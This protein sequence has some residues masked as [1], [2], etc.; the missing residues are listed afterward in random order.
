MADREYPYRDSMKWIDRHGFEHFTTVQ[1]DNAADLVEGV[2]G[3]IA[4]IVGVQEGTPTRVLPA[5]PQTAEPAGPRPLPAA[6]TAR[7]FEAKATP[8]GKYAVNATGDA[9]EVRF[10]SSGQRIAKLKLDC[11]EL[12]GID[13]YDGGWQKYGVTCFPEVLFKLGVDIEALE[14]G[15]YELPPFEYAKVL[16]NPKGGRDKEGAPEKVLGFH[17]E[18]GT[19]TDEA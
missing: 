19:D 3:N 18:D 12:D 4:W 8:K 14:P 15:E 7:K 17:F 1:A 2:D 16:Y 10:T 6:A 13:P 5:A 11:P 9:M